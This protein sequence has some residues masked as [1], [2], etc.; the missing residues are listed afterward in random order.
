MAISLV[1]SNLGELRLPP[2]LASLANRSLFYDI[3]FATL[4]EQRRIAQYTFRTPVRIEGLVTQFSFANPAKCG[5]KFAYRLNFADYPTPALRSDVSASDREDQS[6]TR[7]NN[8]W[9]NGRIHILGPQ[10]LPSSILLAAHC[11]CLK[12]SITL[13]CNLE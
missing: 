12:N 2:T 1:C 7:P 9:T 13:N 5:V 3:N 11:Q 8:L 4:S 6:K 10:L